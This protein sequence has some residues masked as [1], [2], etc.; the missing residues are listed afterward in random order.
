[1]IRALLSGVAL[2]AVAWGVPAGAQAP[3]PPAPASRSAVLFDGRTL[4]GW[5]GD[6]AVWRVEAGAITGG[7]LTR[8]TADTTF[9]ASTREFSD[10][11]LR[12]RFKLTGRDGFVNSGVQIRSQRL[13][14]SAEMI[15]YQCD[16]GDPDWW[17]SVYDESRRDRVLSAS[18]MRTLGPALHRNDWNDYVIRAD[19]PRITTWINGVMGTDYTETDPDIPRTGRLGIQVHGGGTTLVQVKDVTIEPL[20]ATR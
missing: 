6:P 8:P 17:G 3:G 20:P 11:V 5:E 16:I 12:L 7:S 18:D 13:A 10:F 15:G 9:L 4:S 1:V 19:G 14:G 2:V